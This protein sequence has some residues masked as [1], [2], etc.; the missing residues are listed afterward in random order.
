MELKK[1][2]TRPK[3]GLDWAE[4]PKSFPA[5]APWETF[6]AASWVGRICKYPAVPYALL[7]SAS[8]LFAILALDQSCTG[9]DDPLLVSKPT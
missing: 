2:G 8:W 9:Y 4:T 6:S 7:L 3:V 5:L 1:A